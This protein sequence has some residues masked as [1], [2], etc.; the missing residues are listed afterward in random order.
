MKMLNKDY[1][2]INVGEYSNININTDDLS[3]LKY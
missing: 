3:I 2:V 1:S